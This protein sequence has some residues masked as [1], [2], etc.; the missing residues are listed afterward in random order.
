MSNLERATPPKS[1]VFQNLTVLYAS[2]IVTGLL[3]LVPIAFVPQ[4]LD[5]VGIGRLVIATA[6]AGILAKLIMLGTGAYIVREIARDHQRLSELLPSTVVLRAGLALL[7]LPVTTIILYLFD[8]PSETNVIVLI[9]YGGLT[10]NMISTTFAEA[11]Q[12]LENM[13]WRSAASVVKEVVAVAFGWWVLR[14]GGGLIGYVLV[15]ALADVVEFVVH[16]SYF[17][18][19]I[20]IRPVIRLGIISQVFRGGLPFFLWAFIQTIYYHTSSLMLS[21][22]G[23]EEA[24]G[25]FGVANQFI[26]PL[27]MLPSVVITV[28]LPRFSQLSQAGPG[29]LRQAVT[30]AMSYMTIVTLPMA[31]GLAALAGRVIDLFNYSATFQHSVPVLQ[32]LAFTLPGTSLLMVAACTLTAMNQERGWARISVFSLGAAIVINAALIPL[33]Q[34]L[35]NAALGAAGAGLLVELLTYAWALRLIGRSVFDTQIFTTF[36]KA[37]LAA[38]AMAAVLLAAHAVPLPLVIPLGGA[39]YLAVAL[40]LEVF[41]PDDL[42]MARTVVA[43]RWH[44]ASTMLMD[45]ITRAR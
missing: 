1:N 18:L 37:S 5:A 30:R 41:P 33:G 34:L 31:F 40:L 6:F 36:G 29:E 28:L 39:T 4:Y 16:V 9:M 14:Q 7:L 20:R 2:P 12:A 19:R 43:S 24:V 27:F 22:L 35:G 45:R 26:I 25:W 38:G 15:L 44:A 32:L 17:V 21:K 3:S 10:I 8:Y 23:G 42:S 11:L 13:I